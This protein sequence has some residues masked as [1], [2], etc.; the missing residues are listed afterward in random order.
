MSGIQKKQDYFGPPPWLLEVYWLS[1]TEVPLVT[2][3]PMFALPPKYSVPPLTVTPDCRVGV[4]EVK[5]MSFRLLLL[6]PIPGPMP[7]PWLL[8][9][10]V[11]VVKAAT[12]VPAL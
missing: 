6:P 11:G 4:P 8:D 9:D 1:E 7:P 10:L 2:V 12:S 5:T 3:Q